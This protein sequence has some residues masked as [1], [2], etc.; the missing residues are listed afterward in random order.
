MTRVSLRW[1]LFRILSVR[2][3]GLRSCGKSCRGEGSEATIQ[4]QYGYDPHRNVG[5]CSSRRVRWVKSRTVWQRMWWKLRCWGGKKK[6]KKNLLFSI[7]EKHTC[8][9]KNQILVFPFQ[10]SISVIGTSL[11]SLYFLDQLQVVN[12]VSVSPDI[13]SS[14]SSRIQL[15]KYR[16]STARLLNGYF[17]QFSC[18]LW[19]SGHLPWIFS[20]ELM[21]SQKSSFFMVL[22]N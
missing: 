11:H 12:F 22:C 17:Y 21:R 7:S 18:H 15:P 13:I 1:L 10:M 9:L 6:Q 3:A 20:S 14:C 16:L 2:C 4:L 19:Y 5:C 8:M